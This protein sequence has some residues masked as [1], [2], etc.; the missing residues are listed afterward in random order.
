LVPATLR[1]FTAYLSMSFG[2]LLVR[3]TRK[4]CSHSQEENRCDRHAAI[5][6]SSDVCG[7]HG[8]R[9]DQW[10][11]RSENLS[12]QPTSCPMCSSS[13]RSE[14]KRRYRKPRTTRLGGN[15]AQKRS[16][17]SGQ[18]QSVCPR[19]V[20]PRGICGE[21]WCVPR[22]LCASTVDLSL[23][24]TV[25]GPV[26]A[27]I[28]LASPSNSAVNPPHTVVTA[29]AQGGKRRAAGRAGYRER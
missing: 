27:A 8:R 22:R 6:N 18:R 3:R 5:S 20:L 9:R 28:R 12:A 15:P 24:I 14:R 11:G 23:R 13:L 25:G 29:L 7:H 1:R 17:S 19:I 16:R 2:R 4:G 26:R 21:L 10:L